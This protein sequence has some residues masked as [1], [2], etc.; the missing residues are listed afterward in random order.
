MTRFSTWLSSTWNTLKNAGSKVGAFIGKAAPIIRTVVNAMSYLP[1]KVGEIG[2]VIN[3]YS[4]MI[5]GFT[6]LLPD[7][8]LKN[9]IIQYTGNVNQAFLQQQNPMKYGVLNTSYNG[10]K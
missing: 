8:P 3:H 2:K 1:G 10:Q 5:D 9:K 6:G 7:S 4:G